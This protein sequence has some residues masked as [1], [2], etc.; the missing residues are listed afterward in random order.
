VKKRIA[1]SVSCL[2]LFMLASLA[3]MASGKEFVFSQNGRFVRATKAPT[4]ITATPQEDPT[5]KTIAGNFSTY[6]NAT[7]SASGEKL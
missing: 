2:V 1:L 4:H 7:Y 6:T 5:L 3:L